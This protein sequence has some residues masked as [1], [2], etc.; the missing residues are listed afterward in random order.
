MATLKEIKLKEGKQDGRVLCEATE[1][2]TAVN[3][4]IVTVTTGVNW[5]VDNPSS[6][7]QKK[8]V[9]NAKIERIGEPVR[10]FAKTMYIKKIDNSLKKISLGDTAEG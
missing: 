8:V 5:K 4:T 3:N 1:G 7:L 6:F 9:I 2:A 10:S